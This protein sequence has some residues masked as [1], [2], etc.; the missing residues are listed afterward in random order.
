MANKG[1]KK[2]DYFYE[3]PKSLIAE[4]PVERR[5][6]S[7]LLVYDRATKKIEHK[8]FS[9]IIDYFQAG[10][11]LVLNNTR[12]MRARL[13]GEKKQTRGKVEVFLLKKSRKL[14]NSEEWQ[15]LLRG[16]IEVDLEIVLSPRL[17]AVVLQNNQDGTW[18]VRF[19]LAGLAL[20]QEVDRIG[21][22]PLPP[23]IRKGLA[24]KGDESRYQTVFS[25][26]NKTGSVA[27]PTAGLHFTKDLLTKLKA[28]GVEI[29]EVT[30]HVGLGTF[31]PVKTELLLDHKMHSEYFEISAKTVKQITETKKLGRRVIAVGTTATRTL[32]S[33]AGLIFLNSGSK[34]S[35][36]TNIFIYPGYKFELVDCLI[37]NFHLPESTLL[38]LLA[39]FLEQKGGDGLKT[40]KKIYKTAIG[41]NYRF[42]SYG[43]AM[44]II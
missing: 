43:D 41:K 16:K 25:K 29:A 34:I 32:E 6:Q 12:V 35:G 8:I 3:L 33:V 31:A 40:E 4:E 36:W 39:S 18:Q 37:T 30:L 21:H 42:F 1:L 23:Y 22:V 11:L 28:R 15:V 5:D 38:M 2:S 13:L 27:A 44:L 20:N 7:R 9:D 17:S 19:S 24:S 10:D 26:T 14:K